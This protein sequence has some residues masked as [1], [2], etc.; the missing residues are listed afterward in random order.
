MS[1]F[2]WQTKGI[3]E[4]IAALSLKKLPKYAAKRWRFMA[5]EGFQNSF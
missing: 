2:E 4:G 1:D 3:F 5:V